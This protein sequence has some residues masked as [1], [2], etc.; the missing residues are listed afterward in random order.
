VRKV[1]IVLAVFYTGVLSVN[2]ILGVVKTPPGYV[3]LGTV[4]HPS[5]YLYYLSQFTQGK[6]RWLTTV[7]LY[8]SEKIHPSLAWFTNVLAGHMFSLVNISPILAYQLT[9]TIY[10]FLFFLLVIFF[11]EAVFPKEKEAQCI[12]FILLGIANVM[13]GSGSFFANFTEP[14]TRFPRAP[15]H[16]LGLVCAMLPMILVLKWQKSHSLTVKCFQIILTIGTSILLANISP[17]QWILVCCTLISA[18]VLTRQL[19]RVFIVPAIF[20]FSGLP[21]IFYLVNLF[22]TLPFVQSAVWDIGVQIRLSLIDFLKSF[23]PVFVLAVLGLPL[24]CKRLTLARMFILIYT[25]ASIVL[26]LSPISQYAGITNFRFL[27]AVT[28]LGESILTAYFFIRLPIANHTVRRV[29]TWMMVVA[30]S[31]FFIPQFI[32]QFKQHANLDVSNSYVYLSD[33]AI[34]VYREAQKITNDEDTVLVTW[35]FD[36]SF[37][38]ITG[39]RGFMGHPL[40]TID[41]DKKNHD[42][43]LFFDAQMDDASMHKFLTD[44]H[45]T[46][47]LG[48]TSVTKIM[49]PFLQVAYQN[50]LVTLYKVLPSSPL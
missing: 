21:M 31:V 14:M 44:N 28:I 47:V 29:L 8:T 24:F 9:V 20:L 3:Y 49:K 15:H 42:A 23:G 12:A 39:R 33:E 13:P 32:I 41:S 34:S 17:I 7:D 19:P 10:T 48:F 30:L 45:I 25:T 26:F 38:A 37:P 35:P 43:Y 5:D 16:M 46:Y 40:L 22:K 1:L 11:L 27:S 36:G 4:H 18:V 2:Y 50:S 6:T